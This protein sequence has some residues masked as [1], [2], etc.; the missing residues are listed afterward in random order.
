MGGNVSSPQRESAHGRG[1]PAPPSSIATA[2][3]GG[4]PMTSMPDP[5]TFARLAMVLDARRDPQDVD[6][7]DR[8]AVLMRGIATGTADHDDPDVGRPSPPSRSSRP[9]HSVPRRY[10]MSPMPPTP[11]SLPMS[12][13]DSRPTIAV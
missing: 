7:R 2:T 9:R 8:L 3:L 11:S 6:E 1:P 5:V 13:T 12:L 10:A 4:R